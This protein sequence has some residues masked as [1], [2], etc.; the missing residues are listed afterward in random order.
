MFWS[1]WRSEGGMG[2]GR[3]KQILSNPLRSEGVKIQDGKRATRGTKKGY[4]TICLRLYVN[5]R[6]EGCRQE[7]WWG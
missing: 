7:R 6:R 5:A 2:R 1:R 4:V 3:K